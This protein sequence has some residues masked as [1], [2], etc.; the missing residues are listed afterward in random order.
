[1]LVIAFLGFISL[2]LP[3]AVIGVAWPSVRDEFKRSQSGL[4]L[5]LA[6]VGTGYFLSSFFAGRL[7]QAW[8]I[9][10]L[11]A[12]SSVLVA[13]SGWGYA[14]APAWLAF[15]AC[16]VMHGLGS[17]AIDAGLN[18]YA[19][20]HFRPRHMNWLHAC[21]CLGAML[22][23]L[24]ITAILAGG[25]SWRAGYATLGTV[26]LLLSVLFVATHRRWNRG[27]PPA[28]DDGRRHRG[29]IATLK[30]PLVWLH[31]VVF[32]FYTG[33][34]VTV[35]QWSFTLFT[36]ARHI[37]PAAAGLWVSLYWGSIGVGR[38]LL[39]MLVEGMGIDRLVRLST[40]LAVLGSVL[41]TAPQPAALSLLGLLL[42]GL[43]LAPVFPC[44]M[45]RTPQRLGADYAA[46]AIGFQVSAAMVGAAVVPSMVGL[47]VQ[48]FGLSMV[49]LA[50]IALALT[51]LL[52]HETLL[53]RTRPIA[54]S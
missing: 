11:L 27:A 40:F 14:L 22:G 8:G 32:F 38:V 28:I 25:G 24:L 1:M 45:T 31:I 41:L 26:M 4:G 6:G 34:E 50:A 30:H 3:D 13:V 44:L 53:R 29:T 37:E 43:A 16:S 49:P 19:A 39:G 17:G 12:A 51:L 15:V 20:S 42:I 33:M 36:E 47:A 18:G 9:G 5:V 52:L 10:A 23:P 7:I 46:H 21:Y 2:G 54:D 48:Q 35:G